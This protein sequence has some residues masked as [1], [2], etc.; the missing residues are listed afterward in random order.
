MK[1]PAHWKAI[2]F[3]VHEDGTVTLVTDFLKMPVGDLAAEAAGLPGTST[4]RLTTKEA[5]RI[6]NVLESWLAKQ[7]KTE[8]KPSKKA[9]QTRAGDVTESTRLPKAML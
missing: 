4:Y 6:G 9:L 7:A 1:R 5:V 8:E 2:D 3:E